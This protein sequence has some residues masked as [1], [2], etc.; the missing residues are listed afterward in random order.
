M[1]IRIR[2][3]ILPVAIV[4][5]VSIGP[6][7][8]QVALAQACYGDCDGDGTL[9]SSDLDRIIDTILLCPCAENPAAGAAG[10][11]AAI[12]EGCAAADFDGDG[13]IGPGDLG[14]ASEN[15]LVFAPSGCAPTSTPTPGGAA[16]T[17]TP[18]Q[19]LVA[20]TP[21]PTPDSLCG[22]GL[23]SG[24][25]TCESCPTDC[26]VGPC[27]VPTPAPTIT[28]RV[29]WSPP[30]GVDA[31]STTVRVAY[32]STLVSLP[33]SGSAPASRVTLRPP[34]S[35]VAVNDLDYALRVV[36]TRS[37]AITPGRLFNVNFDRCGG[38]AA[39]TPSDFACTVEG[40]ASSFGDV[41]GCTCQVVTP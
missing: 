27:T 19:T 15:A 32:R 38:A 28:F 9:G 34:N 17:P 4:L 35:I 6:P 25:E 29:N 16:A 1:S 33:G 3:L 36:I 18:T 23:L 22:D 37:G 7:S 11:C 5:G 26:A 8:P 13:C 40:C 39:P 21:T 20:N 10:G 24:S 14:R 41:A 31:S 30:F 2:R 12:P